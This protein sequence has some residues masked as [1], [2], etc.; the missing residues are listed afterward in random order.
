VCPLLV[1]HRRRRKPPQGPLSDRDLASQ[2][3]GLPTTDS[4]MPG[5]HAKGPGEVPGPCANSVSGWCVRRRRVRSLE[6]AQLGGGRRAPPAPSGHNLVGRLLLGHNVVSA[7]AYE[8]SLRASPG[9]KR[10]GSRLSKL[11]GLESRC[12]STS[13][14]T[15]WPLETWPS[16]YRRGGRPRVRPVCHPGAAL[17]RSLTFRGSRSPRRRL[18]R[19]A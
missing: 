13:G 19:C 3:S 10:G 15:S 17:S 5:G 6:T 4:T 7:G 9:L 18:Y 8:E 16:G 1:R 11:G 12:K 14:P 2:A